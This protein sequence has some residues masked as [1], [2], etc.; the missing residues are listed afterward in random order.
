MTHTQLKM[1]LLGRLEWRYVNA[2]Q[3]ELEPPRPATTKAQ[4]L[5]A[6]LVFYQRKQHAR[7]R[8]MEMF[9]GDRSERKARRS[10]ST[11]LWHIRRCM[12]G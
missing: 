2:G 4:S 10:L 11:A 12:P 6:Y 8:L 9:W 5:L 7:E 1:R 3:P